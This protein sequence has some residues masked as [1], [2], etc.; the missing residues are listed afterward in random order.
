M[1]EAWPWAEARQ[2]I[3]VQSALFA[4]RM[5]ELLE[6]LAALREWHPTLTTIEGLR[7]ALGV[8]ERLATLLGA[9][10]AWL[11]WPRR[12]ADDEALL[13]IVASIVDYLWRGA[14]NPHAVAAGADASVI[15]AGWRDWL[16]LLLELIELLQALRGAN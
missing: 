16:P 14:A 4:G 11:T 9:D 6:L 1:R 2:G 15:A 7:G 13:A 12:V 5:R 8:V 10:D 3:E